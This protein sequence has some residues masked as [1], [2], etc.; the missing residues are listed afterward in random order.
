MRFFSLVPPRH[1]GTLLRVLLG[2][3]GFSAAFGALWLMEYTQTTETSG[4]LWWKETR[5]IPIEERQPSLLIAL[6]LFALA[7]ILVVLAVRVAWHQKRAE[8]R[9]RLEREAERRRREH[10]RW[11]RTPEGAAWEAFDRGDR[12]HVVTLRVLPPKHRETIRA[13]EAV[14][15]VFDGQDLHPAVHTKESKR[16]LDGGHTVVRSSIQDATFYFVR[17]RSS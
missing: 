14:G 9:V 11:L 4:M 6:S 16:N 10:E 15:W 8:V 2:L 13:I 12:E 1:L 5:Q 7:T 17:P 3:A